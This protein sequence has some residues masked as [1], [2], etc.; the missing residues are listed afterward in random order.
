MWDAL[1]VLLMS[2]CMYYI[3]SIRTY[4]DTRPQKWEIGSHRG[5]NQRYSFQIDLDH[6]SSTLQFLQFW[7]Q[8]GVNYLFLIVKSIEV[9]SGFISKVMKKIARWRHHW[10]IWHLI[11][12]TKISLLVV[13]YQGC[14]GCQKN[15]Q[16]LSNLNLEVYCANIQPNLTK[17]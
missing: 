17:L 2:P 5:R 1:C 14:N 7:Y 8:N 10:N 4:D 16:N 3:S 6:G 13:R 15:W 12:K 9:T 11:V